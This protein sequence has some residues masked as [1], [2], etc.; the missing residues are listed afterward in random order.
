MQE[1]KRK[2]TLALRGKNCRIDKQTFVV[3]VGA[4]K[5]WNLDMARMHLV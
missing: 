1:L 2:N 5:A 4:F 3:E